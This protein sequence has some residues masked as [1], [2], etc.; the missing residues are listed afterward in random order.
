MH[1]GLEER[2]TTGGISVLTLH[3]AADPEKRPG[4]PAGDVW[5]RKATQGYPGG[6]A[7][8]RWQKEMEIRYGALGGQ[9][10]F[11]RWEEWRINGH[12]VV[13]HVALSGCTLYGSY[14]HGWRHNACY[15]V[16]AMDRDGHATT[17]WECRAAQVPVSAWAKIIQ[18]KSARLVDGREFPGNP[19]AG[20]EVWRVADPSIWNEGNAQSSGVNKSTWELFRDAG[21]IFRKGERGGD[22]TAAEYLLGYW[23]EDPMAPRYRIVESCVGLIEEIGRQRFREISAA[24]ALHKAAPEELVD[25]D[26][27]AF[28]ALKYFLLKFPPKAHTPKPQEQPNTWAFWRDNATRA[29]RGLPARSFQREMVR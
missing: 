22:T 1:D 16:H 9:A 15:L 27:D 20:K 8:P 23:W 29:R 19:Y 10:L 5:L 13:A 24:V 28:D 25:K 7:S 26:N 17:V 3:Y 12:I 6:I 18:G 11:P 4:T 14:D 2:I 21:V